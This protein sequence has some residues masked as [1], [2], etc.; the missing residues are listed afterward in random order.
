MP[1]T[2]LLL[3]SNQLLIQTIE[4]IKIEMRLLLRH[5]DMTNDDSDDRHEIQLKSCPRCKTAIRKSLRY[6]NV[7]KQQLHDIEQVKGKVRGESDE[8]IK[9]KTKLETRLVVLK[10]TFSGE[11]EMKEWEKLERSLRRMSKGSRTS[12][13]VTENQ[14]TLMERFCAISQKLKDNLLSDP[15]S[16]VSTQIRME[17]T[18]MFLYYGFILMHLS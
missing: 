14:V 11:H 17:G 13:V 10:G 18:L 8:V 3:H 15:H 6:G 12:A 5:M 9:T 4:F 7:I 2:V 16:Q 1:Q